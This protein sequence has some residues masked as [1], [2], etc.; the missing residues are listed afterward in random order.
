MD[1]LQIYRGSNINLIATVFIILKK[2][3]KLNFNE[4]LYEIY[5]ESIACAEATE[6]IEA[7]GVWRYG[8]E[9]I[10]LMKYLLGVGYYD[11]ISYFDLIYTIVNKNKSIKITSADFELFF[12]L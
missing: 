9:A 7:K 8:Y 11:N 2:N 4:T 1:V 6:T 10:K 12:K 3:G 5:T